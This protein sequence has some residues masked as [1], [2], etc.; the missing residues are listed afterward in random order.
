[1][2]KKLIAMVLTVLMMLAFAP[3]VIHAAP[4][5]PAQGDLVIHKY[6]MDSVS[7][8]GSPGNGTVLAPGSLPAGATPLNKIPF[9]I[10]QVTIPQSGIYPAPGAYT[11]DDYDNPT[12]ITDSNVDKF[13]VTFT[14]TVTTDAAGEATAS[15]LNQGVYLVVEQN[16]PQ[17]ASPAAPFVVSVPMTD[18][19]GTG[20]LTTVHV[21]P[22]NENLTVEKLVSAPSVQVGDV[23]TFSIIPTVPAE[24]SKAKGY[25]VIDTLDEALDYLASSGVS[26]VGADTKANLATGTPL[27]LT[28]DYTVSYDPS[29]RELKVSLTAAGRSAAEAAKYKFLKIEF[30]AATNA[31][32]LTKANH[33][34][35]NS[36][37]LDFVNQFDQQKLSNSNTA[38]THTGRIEILKVDAQSNTE[39]ANAEFKIASSLINAQNGVFLRKDAA[40]NILDS[41]DTGYS[42]ATDWVETTAANGKVSFDGIRDLIDTSSAPG[43]GIA[44][45]SYWLVETKAPTGGYNLL[46]QPEEVTFDSTADKGNNFTMGVTIKNTKGFQLPQTGGA[47][48][49]I[50][51]VLGVALIGAAFIL[52]MIRRKNKAKQD[53]K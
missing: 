6:L 39:L 49:L 18:V 14:T 17:V 53:S 8:A 11:L 5:P 38:G 9:K 33:T 52:M 21:Y 25:D 28:T 4:L 15:G 26:V 13:T 48:T 42:A 44:Y 2:K 20:W 45:Q 22:K 34:V 3:S 27:S 51:T 50:F 7:N 16:D 31:K 29:T 32:I 37:T 24:L 46:A 40:G 10:Y 35:T 19:A 43:G 12:E 47:G 23:L 36:A 41:T 1:M 30:E